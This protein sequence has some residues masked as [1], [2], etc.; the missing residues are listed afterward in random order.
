MGS[1]TAATPRSLKPGSK[2]PLPESNWVWSPQGA[3]NMHMPERWGYVQFS[4]R[5]AGSTPAE[6][7][8]ADPNEAVKWA[9][10]RLY[11]RQRAFRTKTGR[12]AERADEA[13]YERH[14]SR[15]SP[16]SARDEGDRLALRDRRA[17]ISRPAA[18][19]RSGRSRLG[20]ERTRDTQGENE[21]HAMN[22]RDFLQHTFATGAVTALSASSYRS[23][24]TPPS[25]GRSAASIDR[26][27]TG[28]STTP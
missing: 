13:R 24:S 23:R 14:R 3:I 17:R 26:G 21:E 20:N 10:R 5:A 16:I 7:F 8:V 28:P 19:Y 25:R 15:R 22:R 2:Q 9:L 11:Y 12:Y 1:P 18:P 4:S 27:R 6:A